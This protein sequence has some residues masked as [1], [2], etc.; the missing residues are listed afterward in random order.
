MRGGDATVS[1]ACMQQSGAAVQARQQPLAAGRR[2]E[3]KRRFGGRSQSDVISW[4]ELVVARMQVR[5][6]VV[7]ISG[8]VG[9]P[10]GYATAHP[11]HPVAT[12]LL[13]CIAVFIKKNLFFF[14]KFY[15]VHLTSSA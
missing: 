3:P 10:I 1:I 6:Q 5:L 12:P 13:R 8:L 2:E 11:D 15:L 7:R 9:R 4:T 14:D